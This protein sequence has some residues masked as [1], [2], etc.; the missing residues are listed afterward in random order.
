MDVNLV[1]WITPVAILAVF[2]VTAGPFLVRSARAR[3]VRAKLLLTGVD[4]MAT[5]IRTWDT[6]VRINDNP[7]VGMLVEVQPPGGDPF[8]AEVTQTISIVHLPMVQPGARLYVRCDPAVPREVALV[9]VI[10]T[11]ATADGPMAIPL[12]D[13][14][15]AHRILEQRQAANLEILRTGVSAPAKVLEYAPTGILVNGENP[16]VN[17]TVEVQPPGSPSFTAQTFGQAVAEA[18]IPRYQPGRT[19]TVRYDPGNLTRVVVERSGD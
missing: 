3:R 7:Q 11:E 5:L 18:S 2:G 13:R 8:R 4:A 12:V 17:L 15:E 14:R 9:S 16:M 19:V 6:H 1:P 10:G